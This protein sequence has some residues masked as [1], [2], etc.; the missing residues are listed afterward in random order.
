MRK[1]LLLYLPLW[2]TQAWYPKL[3]QLLVAP[4]IVLQKAV[5]YLP[6]KK[7]EIHQQDSLRLVVCQISGNTTEVKE[8]QNNQLHSCVH[9][10]EVP[11]LHNKKAIIGSGYLSVLK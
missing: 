11:Q 9:L 8:Y 2:P 6:F 5:L 4:P 7:N 10:G 1:E 3:M